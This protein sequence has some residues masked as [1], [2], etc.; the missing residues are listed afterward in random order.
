MQLIQNHLDDYYSPSFHFCAPEGGAKKQPESLG[1]ILFASAALAKGPGYRHHARAL[2][3]YNDEDDSLF[4]REAEFDDED[5]QFSVRDVEDLEG[6]AYL[7]VRDL[8]SA[9]GLSFDDTLAHLQRRVDPFQVPIPPFGASLVQK[10]G[11]AVVN[12]PHPQTG[13]H[14]PHPHTPPVHFPS[15]PKRDLEDALAYL[16]RRVDPLQT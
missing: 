16:E 11:S 8:A 12:R 2:A 5:N 1:S 14:F 3:A 13:N 15:H 10:I 4:A 9:A 6:E 7:A